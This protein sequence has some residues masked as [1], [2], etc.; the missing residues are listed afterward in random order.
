MATRLVLGVNS[1]YHESSACLLDGATVL[2]FVEEE[3]FTRVKRAKRLTLDNADQL[4]VHAIRH[5][6]EA[7]G[8]TW[9]D[10]SH[11]AYGYD[12]RLR[13]PPRDHEGVREGSWGSAAGERLFL[14]T[15]HRVP[16]VL[17]EL[18]GRDLTPGFRWVGHHLAHAASAYFASP[19]EDAAV[20]SVDALGEQAST[21]LAHGNGTKLVVLDEILYPHSLGFLWEAFSVFLGLDRYAGPAKLMGLAA[22]GRGDRFAGAMARVLRVSRDGFTIDDTWT[23]FRSYGNDRLEEL[24]GP[25]REP[26]SEM[27]HRDADLARA[28]QEATEEALLALANR[29]RRETGA[30]ALCLAGGVALNCVGTGRLNRETEFDGF[31]VQPAAND[32]GTALGAALYVLHHELGLTDRYVM[33]HPYTG[34]A[35][36]EDAMRAAVEEAGLPY[37]RSADVAADTARLLAGGAVIGWFQGAMEIGPRALG[38]RSIV[39][40]PRSPVVKDT[41]NVRAKHREYWR[42]FSPSVLRE[43]AEDWLVVGGESLSHGFMSYT[44]PVLPHRRASMPAAVHA[45]GCARAQLVTPELNPRYHRMISEFHALTGVPVVLNTSFNGP[46]E[47]IVRTPAEAVRMYLRNGLDALVLGDLVVT[48]RLGALGLTV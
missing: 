43:H 30:P 27:D 16:L 4:P 23:R 26:G 35:Y 44:Y 1:V 11:V 7:A 21:M 31:F 24:F 2:S 33:T 15:V 17:S 10:V 36:D 37:T 42:P 3:R 41:I 46:E 13:P 25:R 22:F 5:C 6:L 18:A 9:D 19:Y 29:L 47:P 12:P 38:N 28:L 20:L 39:A 40:D 32:A 45:D 8:A 48:D 34:P 14:E